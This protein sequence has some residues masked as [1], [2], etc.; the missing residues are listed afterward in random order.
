M[1]RVFPLLLALTATLA[2][3]GPPPDDPAVVAYE[4]LYRA[5][6][7]ADAPRAVELMTADSVR[8]LAERLGLPA[9]SAPDAVAERLALRPGWTFLVDLPQQAKVDPMRSDASRRVVVGPLSGA[10]WAFPVVEVDGAWRVDLFAADH[11]APSGTKV[12]GGGPDGPR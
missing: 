9:D 3:C 5:F 7:R 10:R 11:I 4:Q 6:A 1:V 8:S 2:G 12:E